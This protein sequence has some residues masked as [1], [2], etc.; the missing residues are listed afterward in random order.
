[1]TLLARA[2]VYASPY[3]NPSSTFYNLDLAAALVA[4]ENISKNT[5]PKIL[6]EA[7]VKYDHTKY[8]IHIF[9]SAILD[10]PAADANLI[11][12]VIQKT[13]EVAGTN[14]PQVFDSAI[15]NHNTSDETINLIF[16]H[17]GS[18]TI[19]EKIAKHPNISSKTLQ[20]IHTSIKYDHPRYVDIITKHTNRD[21]EFCAN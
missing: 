2:P 20:K 15:D 5:D 19:I 7:F 9:R 18:S 14:A 12:Q 13:I 21:Q 11:H 1:M 8:D 4:S 10:S 3:P 16:D 17:R 6:Q